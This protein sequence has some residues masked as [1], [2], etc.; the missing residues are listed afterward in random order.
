MA[1]E[2]SE[3]NLPHEEVN[4]SLI[5]FSSEIET[6]A[7]QSNN[8]VNNI[9]TKALPRLGGSI[10]PIDVKLLMAYSNSL[11]DATIDLN[12]VVDSD[13]FHQIDLCLRLKPDKIK[14][15]RLREVDRVGPQTVCNGYKPAVWLYACHCTRGPQ[16]AT[17]SIQLWFH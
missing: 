8:T 11:G 13:A 7:Q 9:W 4:A 15:R 14:T 1:H 6:P 2:V 16:R 17:P 3:S 12:T 5:K 10:T